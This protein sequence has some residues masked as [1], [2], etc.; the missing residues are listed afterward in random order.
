[1]DT[2]YRPRETPLLQRARA[3]GA[4]IVD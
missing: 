4:V 1:M 2:V 3:A